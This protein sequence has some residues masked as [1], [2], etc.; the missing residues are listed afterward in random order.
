MA[1][2]AH[3]SLVVYFGIAVLVVWRLYSRVRRMVGRQK[4]SARR[5]WIRIVFFSALVAM[6]LLG[7]AVHPMH[8]VALLG[9]AAAGAALGWYGIGLTRFEQTP[10][11]LFYTPS[12]HLGIALS[13]LFI[14]RLVYRGAMLYSASASNTFPSAEFSGSPL[15]LLIFGIL[16]GYYVA[17]AI[18]LL[19]WRRRVGSPGSRTTSGAEMP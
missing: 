1:I 5:T 17:Y 19:L 3:P 13:A 16:A 18:G 11:G 4:M 7:S 9:G 14:G 10:E 6:L 15:T 12:L 2:P 8:A